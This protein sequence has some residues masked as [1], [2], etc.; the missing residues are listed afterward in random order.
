MP[1]SKLTDVSLLSELDRRD[2]LDDRS[3][4]FEIVQINDFTSEE[5]KTENTTLEESGKVESEL[6]C[7]AVTGGPL[8]YPRRASKSL[9]SIVKR[10]DHCYDK[11]ETAIRQRRPLKA[12][13]KK[14]TSKLTAASAATV[15][16]SDEEVFEQLT[17]DKATGQSVLSFEVCFISS[18]TKILF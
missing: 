4:P 16:D 7:W 17:G 13:S 6:V 9:V 8:D 18:S 5:I 15:E 12:I 3:D 11:L 1:A 10:W 2:L 14:T